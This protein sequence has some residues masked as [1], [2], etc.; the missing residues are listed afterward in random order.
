MRWFLFLVLAGFSWSARLIGTSTADDPVGSALMSL[1]CLIIHLDKSK[2]SRPAGLAVRKQTNLMNGAMRCEK[3]AN[4]IFSRTEGQVSDV[5][6][7]NQFQT[8]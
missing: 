1:G 3:I 5:D 7:L 6:F 8:P 2:A 4:F